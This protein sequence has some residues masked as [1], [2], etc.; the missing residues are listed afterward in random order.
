[1]TKYFQNP[2]NGYVAKATDGLTWLWALLFGPFYMAYKGAWPHAIV[3]VIGSV[4]YIALVVN[5]V[6]YA[7]GLFFA[8]CLGYA[9]AIYPIV[10]AVYRR[11]GW[12]AAE[13]QHAAARR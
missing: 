6:P 11:A 9:I 7:D 2:A 10:H 3:Y 5:K 4:L 13:P 8:M 12:V 1:M